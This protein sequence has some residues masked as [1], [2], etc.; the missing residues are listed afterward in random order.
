MA[1]LPSAEQKEIF[2]RRSDLIKFILTFGVVWGHALN[3]KVYSL[4]ELST[5]FSAFVY[6]LEYNCFVLFGLMVPM[7]YFLSGFSYFGN[8]TL[9]TTL[10]KWKRR[11]FTLLIPWLCWN[12]IIWGLNILIRQIP[13]IAS[14]LNTDAEYKLTLRSWFITGLMNSADGPMW[15]IK[16]LIVLTLLS[17]AIYLLIKNKYV[18]IAAIS[19]SLAAVYFTGASRFSVLIS[20]VFF[21]EAGYCSLHLK[22]LFLRRYSRSAR[23]C[24]ASLLLAYMFLCRSESLQEGALAYALTFTVADPAVWVLTGDTEMS[25][26]SK[27]L[28]DYRFWIY[29]SH[30]FLLESIEKL[31]LIFLGTSGYAALA[32]FILA[33]I[34]TLIL[35]IALGWGVKKYLPTVWAVLN[36]HIPSYK[37]NNIVYASIYKSHP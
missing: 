21:M 22:S 10:D 23:L 1:E 17:P 30:Y 8:Y 6:Q 31:F 2:K 3:W 26:R 13:S 19:G 28:N 34:L 25:G 29:S 37:K 5:G 33:P 32:D 14:H 15:F 20:L 4:S 35:V 27:K 24:A 7:F 12:T 18:G 11:F 36:G 16:N 9:A